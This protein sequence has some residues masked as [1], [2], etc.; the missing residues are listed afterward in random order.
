M[1]VNKIPPTFGMGG[2]G[3]ESGR[4]RRMPGCL[5]SK[6]GYGRSPQTRAALESGGG[7]GGDASLTPAT[8]GCRS[9]RSAGGR[10]DGSQAI[11]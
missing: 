4:M 11:D 1:N 7:V 2:A 5:G 8:R 9:C 3:T 6:A 10:V